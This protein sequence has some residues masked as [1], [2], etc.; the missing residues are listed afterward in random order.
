MNAHATN[1]SDEIRK[2]TEDAYARLPKGYIESFRT[3]IGKLVREGIAEIA[4]KIGDDFPDFTLKDDESNLVR[5]SDFW[6]DQN[7]VVK[8]YRG[9][10]CPYCHLE[11]AALERHRP[12]LG[13]E[14]AILFA[15]AP[16]RASFQKETKQAAG[17]EFK[18][19]W[20]ENNTL[21]RRLGIA[22]PVGESV[23]DVYLKLK[24]DLKS[25]NGEWVLPVP[26]TFIVRDGILRYSS[27]DPDYMRRQ[28]PVE[29]LAA[30]RA[31]NL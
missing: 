1:L 25:V 4:P 21:A 23:K 3:L 14:N 28:D 6:K 24:L 26:A 12:E 11:L 17:A 22:F 10:W 27:V 15:V 29:L 16:E 8:F 30:I 7:L 19:L 20:D 5:A 31:V 2:F 9:G 13:A 18:F